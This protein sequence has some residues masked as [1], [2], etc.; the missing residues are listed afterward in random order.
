[1]FKIKDQSVNVLVSSFQTSVFNMC[2]VCDL[3]GEVWADIQVI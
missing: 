3:R 1:M 2:C